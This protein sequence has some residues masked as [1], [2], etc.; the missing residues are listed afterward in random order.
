MIVEP[1]PAPS[2][3][4]KLFELGPLVLL[5]RRLMGERGVLLALAL[6]LLTPLRV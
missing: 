3:A 2:A 1:A 6:L 5:A 4:I